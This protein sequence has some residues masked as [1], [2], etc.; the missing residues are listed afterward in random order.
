MVNKIKDFLETK[1][2]NGEPNSAYKKTQS[3][4]SL[5]HDRQQRPIENNLLN[6]VVKTVMADQNGFVAVPKKEMESETHVKSIM[7]RES[8]TVPGF[9]KIKQEPQKT[10]AF[11]NSSRQKYSYNSEPNSGKSDA[12]CENIFN[13]QFGLE[14]K[15]NI[16]DAGDV[17][18]LSL[19][20]S[21]QKIDAEG[22]SEKVNILN[23]ETIPYKPNSKSINYVEIK[24]KVLELKENETQMQCPQGN[25]LNLNSNDAIDLSLGKD[26]KEVR[27]S[28]ASE[29]IRNTSNASLQNKNV[30]DPV[31]SKVA[32]K[33]ELEEAKGRNQYFKEIQPK[34]EHKPVSLIENPLALQKSL[35]C[36]K[37]CPLKEKSV[38]YIYIFCYCCHYE[39]PFFCTHKS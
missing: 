27:K 29:E 18:D 28:I 9:I 22:T 13:S 16:V 6:K 32:I 12:A 34:Y 30:R 25:D 26:K 15:R 2:I 20:Q 14:N 10:K 31:A 35:T 38:S 3:K 19:P 33:T 5:C 1:S 11:P 24:R 36:V 21:S 4:E 23:T 7:R 37:K 39:T 17:L 8:F